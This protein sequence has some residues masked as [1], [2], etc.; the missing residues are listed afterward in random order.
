MTRHSEWENHK[1]IAQRWLFALLAAMLV[2]PSVA[3]AQSAVAQGAAAHSALGII[4]NF[5]VWPGNGEA[6]LVWRNP[7]YHGSGPLSNLSYRVE[8]RQ[9]SR[10]IV[11]ELVGIADGSNPT[12]TLANLANDIVYEVRIQGRN[13]EDLR[14]TPWTRWILIMPRAPK[15]LARLP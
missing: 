1:A 9:G 14:L 3:T 10:G 15:A 13:L 2:L 12:Y 8:V 6:V 4:R 7:D 11:R 5:A